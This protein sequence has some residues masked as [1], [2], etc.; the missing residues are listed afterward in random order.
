MDL[1]ESESEVDWDGENEGLAG[2]GDEI[3]GCLLKLCG[4][5]CNNNKKFH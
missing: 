3:D 5:G 1:V 4:D 2:G